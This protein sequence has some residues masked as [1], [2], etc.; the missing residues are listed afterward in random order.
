MNESLF[1]TFVLAIVLIASLRVLVYLAL[2]A[3]SPE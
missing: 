1:L 3:S 2:L